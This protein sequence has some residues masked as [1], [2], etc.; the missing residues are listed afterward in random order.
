MSLKK[1]ISACLLVVSVFALPIAA[2]KVLHQNP[3]VQRADG[4]GPQ[5]PPPPGSGNNGSGNL[6]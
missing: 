5:P 2:S 6:A 1:L 3:V 4:N